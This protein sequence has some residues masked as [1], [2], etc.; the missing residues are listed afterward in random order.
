MPSLPLIARAA[1]LFLIPDATTPRRSWREL[2]WNA[3]PSGSFTW[4]SLIRC[5]RTSPAEASG[6]EIGPPLPT[7]WASATVMLRARAT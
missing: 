1:R 5:G 6:A 7:R 3:V 4:S 2:M